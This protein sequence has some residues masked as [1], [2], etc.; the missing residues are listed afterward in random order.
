MAN[1]EADMLAR[2]EADLREA[3]AASDAAQAR[4]QAAIEDAA[5]AAQRTQEMR[6]V[7]DW[8]HA[9]SAERQAPAGQ[10]PQV[11]SA[12]R[13]GRPV[14]ENPV[15]ELSVQALEGIGRQASTKQI[16]ERLARDGHEFTQ[17]QVRNALRYLSKKPNPPVETNSGTG[18][19]RLRPGRQPAPFRPEPHVAGLSVANGTGGRP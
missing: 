14:P 5:A 1:V 4:A 19:W 6:A 9:Q 13:F 11:Q 7:L 15:T 18:L 3:E 10:A 16:R 8:L 12:M 2:A 17:T